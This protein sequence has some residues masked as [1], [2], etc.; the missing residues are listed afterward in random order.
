MYVASPAI[1]A[2]K[3]YHSR[4]SPVVLSGGRSRVIQSPV[5]KASSIN[6]ET[7]EAATADF[8]NEQKDSTAPQKRKE[9]S[10]K[11][12]PYEYIPT[13]HDFGPLINIRNAPAIIIMM[14]AN[15][16]YFHGSRTIWSTQFSFPMLARYILSD[17][18]EEYG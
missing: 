13:Y 15:A 9:Y 8:L 2:K 11:A 12:K 16:K 4:V 7:H 3:E 14:P 6:A 10:R 5:M 17:S 1:V 18:P